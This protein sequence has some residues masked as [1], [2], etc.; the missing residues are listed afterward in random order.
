M[1]K[2]QVIALVGFVL[3]LSAASYAADAPPKTMTAAQFEASLK[4]KKG[5]VA[6]P[7][8]VAT[9]KIP[10]SFRYLD[11]KDAERVLVQAWGNPSGDGT[12]GMLF[13]AGA[14]PVSDNGWGVVITYE[15]DGYVSDKDADSINYDSLIK[16]MK[17][18][19]AESNKEREKQG[20]QTVDLVGW[21]AKP[22]YDKDAHKLY[23]AKELAFGGNAEHT[24]NYNI[25]V[26][27][28][29]GVLVL[30]AVAGMD[31]LASVEKDMRNVL[32]FTDFNPGY[33]YADFDSK[34]DKTATYGI[35]ALVAGG[36]AAKAGLFTKLFAVLLAAK[37][38]VI[39]GVVAIGAFI[40]NLLKRKKTGVSS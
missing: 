16:E 27:G 38:L 12:L 13:P 32:A 8:G 19:T 4:Y 40:A 6:L 9:L 24:L 33:R 36:L 25:R 7:G 22:Y 37:K 23:W 3:L 30:N 17:E 35:A 21:A 2:K 31:Q 34:T 5:E 1:S 15:E 29:R 26:L 11:P 28:R 18:G 20:Y 14:S 10:D 39:V